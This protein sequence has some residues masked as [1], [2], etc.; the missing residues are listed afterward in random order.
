MDQVPMQDQ[1]SPLAEVVSIFNYV[2]VKKNMHQHMASGHNITSSYFLH[3]GYKLVVNYHLQAVYHIVC[4]SVH[5][6][7]VVLG[8]HVHTQKRHKTIKP[9]N[10]GTL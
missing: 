3:S 2:F 5:F 6:N 9:Q 4:N 1:F 8:F 10:I 7:S